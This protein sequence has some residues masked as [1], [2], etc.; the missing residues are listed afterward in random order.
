[1]NRDRDP[2]P[3]P[4]FMR[5][6]PAVPAGLIAGFAIGAFWPWS[7]IWGLFLVLAFPAGVALEELRRSRIRRRRLGERRSATIIPLRPPPDD[8]GAA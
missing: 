7:V 1:M 2:A 6:V 5:Y 8:R 4:G 3:L